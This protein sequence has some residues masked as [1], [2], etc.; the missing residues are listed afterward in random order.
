MAERGFAAFSAR[1]VARRIGYSVGTIYNVFPSLDHLLMAIT[2]RTFDLWAEHLRSCLANSG[3]DRIGAL[4]NG[5]FSFARANRNLW[6][7]IYD[8][9]LPSGITYS[10]T[11]AKRRA[12]L[13]AIVVEEVAADIGVPVS[14]ALRRLARSLIATVHGH[15]SFELNATFELM[16]ETNP[17]EMALQ[18]VREALGAEKRKWSGR[19][20]SNLRPLP[21]EDSALPG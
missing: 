11:D 2:T 16:G 17:A 18:R 7:A 12:A 3:D 15:C 13:T 20:D 1:E 6:M 19:E 14:D 21:P 8:H 9:R 10:E 4:V 5:Y